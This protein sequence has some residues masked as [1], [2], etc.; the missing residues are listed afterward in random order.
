[1]TAKVVTKG[2]HLY[3]LP[4]A[5]NRLRVAADWAINLTNRPIAAQLGLVDPTSPRL[6]EQYGAVSVAG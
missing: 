1:V 6:T 5:A 2:Y 3:A 4:A